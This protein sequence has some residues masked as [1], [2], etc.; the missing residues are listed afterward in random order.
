MVNDFC[1]D[2][3]IKLENVLEKGCKMN[4]KLR[5]NI[6]AYCELETEIESSPDRKDFKKSTECQ[7]QL[8]VLCKVL[9]RTSKK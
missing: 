9:L 2:F 1:F 3:Q 8:T 4:C 5:K 7:K 6:S